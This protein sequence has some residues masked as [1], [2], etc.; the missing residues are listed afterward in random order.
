VENDAAEY[1]EGALGGSYHL[2]RSPA[3]VCHRE[4]PHGESNPGYHLERVVS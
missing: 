1:R 4:Y 2:T 3:D